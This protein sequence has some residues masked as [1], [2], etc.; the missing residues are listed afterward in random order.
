MHC[1]QNPVSGSDSPP[2]PILKIQSPIRSSARPVP[3]TPPRQGHFG[4]TSGSSSTSNSSSPSHNTNPYQQPPGHHSPDITYGLG[5]QLLMS[6]KRRWSNSDEDDNEELMDLDKDYGSE[7][8]LSKDTNSVTIKQEV[9][10]SEDDSSS[11][12]GSDNEEEGK[13]DFWTTQM[14][15]NL[16]H[17]LLTAGANP[18]GES[19]H[20]N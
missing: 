8:F 13:K 6:S 12:A 15:S 20:R 18:L 1:S 17:H 5:S 9:V 4:K 16:Y 7:Y 11:H 19:F 3:M 10:T 2:P 14:M